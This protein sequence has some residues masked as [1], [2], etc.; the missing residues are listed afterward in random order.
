MFL[1]IIILFIVMAFVYTCRQHIEHFSSNA[2]PS[3]NIINNIKENVS[4]TT[5]NVITSYENLEDIVKSK[6]HIVVNPLVNGINKLIDGVNEI[7]DKLYT[8][9]M[10]ASKNIGSKVKKYAETM[11]S[12]NRSPDDA[13]NLKF[14]TI[15][16]RNKVFIDNMRSK[17]KALYNT[18][19]KAAKQFYGI[20]F[21]NQEDELIKFLTTI[22]KYNTQVNILLQKHL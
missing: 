12:Y 3:G 9:T 7:P 21:D 1:I 6:I 11:T 22:S 20:K 18:Y 4:L 16:K 19:V 8:N 10:M 2:M 15:N 14:V 17:N 5:Q 13:E